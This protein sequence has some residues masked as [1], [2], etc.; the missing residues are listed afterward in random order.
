MTSRICPIC[1]GNF[2]GR[3][4]LAIHV[5][6]SRSCAEAVEQTQLRQ[7]NVSREQLGFNF[8]FRQFE[9]EEEIPNPPQMTEEALTGLSGEHIVEAASEEYPTFDNINYCAVSPGSVDTGSTNETGS[10]YN[11]TLE[12]IYR[13]Q[14]WNKGNGLSKSD[15]NDLLALLLDAR[16]NASDIQVKNANDVEKFM[17]MFAAS[18]FGADV[19]AHSIFLLPKSKVRNFINIIPHLVY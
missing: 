13:M 10:E 11:T 12:L 14:K 8:L 15:Q 19:S 9:R 2:S 3:N 4:G 1:L 6:K 16:F 17:D 18:A 5:A 7:R